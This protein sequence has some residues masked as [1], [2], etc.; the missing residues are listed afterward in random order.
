MANERGSGTQSAGT[1]KNPRLPSFSDAMTTEKGDSIRIVD[2]EEG[3]KASLR[4]VATDSQG[5]HF[6][7]DITLTMADLKMLANML[8]N[9]D[10][11]AMGY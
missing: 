9:A 2:I 1:R 8:E 10:D 7:G 5:W 11:T 3:T 6:A 4:I